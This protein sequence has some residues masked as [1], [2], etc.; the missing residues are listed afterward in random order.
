MPAW[1]GA[2]CCSQMFTHQL[3]IVCDPRGKMMLYKTKDKNPTIRNLAQKI[4][5]RWSRPV[6]GVGSYSHRRLHKEVDTASGK[7]YTKI[8]ARR[9][10]RSVDRTTKH[11]QKGKLDRVSHHV[12]GTVSGTGCE[13]AGM[14]ARSW[15]EQPRR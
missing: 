7:R 15:T 1:L 5:D 9:E 2:P 13:L 4:I 14:V 11:N 12:C 6:L 10:Q 8:Q 3:R